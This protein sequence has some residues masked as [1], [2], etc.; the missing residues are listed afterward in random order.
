MTMNLHG[1]IHMCRVGVPH[2][3]IPPFSMFQYRSKLEH[4]TGSQKKYILVKKVMKLVKR[5]HNRGGG[6]NI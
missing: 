3:R 6:W 1:L 5:V 2:N 4:F